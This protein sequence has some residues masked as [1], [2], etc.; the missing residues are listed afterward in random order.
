M[1]E[2][3]IAFIVFICVCAIVI[4][5]G[6]WLLSLIGIAIPQPLLIILGILVFLV[7]FLFLM[8]YTNI[9]HLHGFR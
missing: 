4:V 7:L 8:D 6:R 9:Y 2:F 1:I 3:L 5:G